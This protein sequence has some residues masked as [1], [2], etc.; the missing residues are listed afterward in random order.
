MVLRRSLAIV[1]QAVTPRCCTAKLSSVAPCGVLVAAP[2]ACPG[3][4]LLFE[5]MGYCTWRILLRRDPACLA[6]A[7]TFSGCTTIAIDVSACKD[8]NLS[9]TATPLPGVGGTWDASFVPLAQATDPG[10]FE[11]CVRVKDVNLA[12]IPIGPD[13]EVGRLVFDII[14]PTEE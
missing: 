10:V 9:P 1:A 3:N 11:V 4:E 13:V 8:P 12:D 7:Q 14:E 6:A 5:P 2:G